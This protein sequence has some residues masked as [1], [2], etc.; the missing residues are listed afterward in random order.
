MIEGLRR[1]SNGLQGVLAGTHLRIITKVSFNNL[2]N[3]ILSSFFMLVFTVDLPWFS[4]SPSLSAR[5]RFP[6]LV[7]EV[8]DPERNG[9]SMPFG[10]D[11][12][13]SFV[14]VQYPQDPRDSTRYT[15]PNLVQM[16]VFPKMNHTT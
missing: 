16:L 8:P 13:R 11:I 14:T 4:F 6:G 3:R 9:L 5:F 10:V 1:P 15:S 7:R 12:V 2:S